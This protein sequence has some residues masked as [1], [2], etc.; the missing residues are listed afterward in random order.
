MNAQKTEVFD[1]L[2]I[3]IKEYLTQDKKYPY[4]DLLRHGMNALSLEMKKSLPFPKTMKGF[5]QLLETPVKDWCPSRYISKEFDSDFGLLDEGSFS[6]EANDYL[7]EVLIKK[8]RIPEYAST[9]VKQLAIDHAKFVRIIENLQ[10]VY[11]NDNPETAQQEYLL[12]R[13]FLIQNLYTTP[14]KIRKTFLRTKYIS[15]QEIGELYEEC[16]ENQT[17]W[18]CDRCGGL[19]EKHGRLK[20]LKPSLCG[21]HHQNQSYVHRVKW[22]TELLRIKDGIHQRVCFP[23]IPELDLY[24][25]LEE[26]KEKHP[27][28]LHQVKL[29][30]GVDRYDLQLRFGDDAIWAIDFKDVRDPYKLAQNLKPLYSEGSL[31]YNESFYVISDRCIENYPDYLE[32]AR[33]EAKNLPYETHLVSDKVFRTQVNNKITEQQK[34]KL[35]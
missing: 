17:Y 30:P 20:G 1:Y 2:V 28:C 33:K 7:A 12:F 25:A 23:G 15:S 9:I 34:G 29:Y 19:T 31:R 11:N 5:L 3:G 8:G 27:D 24:S 13:R 26:L 6:E 10:D 18:Y 4:P 22:E 14:D 16:Q 35:S 32:I 21:N